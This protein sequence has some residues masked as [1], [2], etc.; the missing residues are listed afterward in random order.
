[1]KNNNIHVISLFPKVISITY[2][3]NKF[4]DEYNLIKKQYEMVGIHYNNGYSKKSISLSVLDNFY[5]LK[6]S[7]LQKFYEF[8]NQ[9]L[10]LET[11][12]FKITTSWLT[13]TEKNEQ[14]IIHTHKNSY[15]SG[16]LYLD[17]IEDITKT[18]KLELISMDESDIA[19]N[20]PTQY[21]E[22][23]SSIWSL[24]P[25]KNLLIFFPSSI[26]HKISLH[27]STLPRYSIAFN[28]FPNGNFGISDSSISINV[29]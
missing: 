14:S 16:I 8:K 26:H 7:I 3:D 12:D 4:D 10:K 13:K 5:E 24:S 28:I 15:Y 6:Q 21:N 20:P 1:M 11:T 22:Y 23:N 29:K 17:D 19:P 9:Y 18:G 27:T 2:L 25:Q